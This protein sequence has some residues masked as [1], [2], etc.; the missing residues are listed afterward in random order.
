MVSTR[1]ECAGQFDSSTIFI[2]THWDSWDRSFYWQSRLYN[3]N[4]QPPP[5]HWLAIHH[6][7]HV[8]LHLIVSIFFCKFTVIWSFLLKHHWLNCP[9]EKLGNTSKS[10]INCWSS[11]NH[12]NVQYQ[13]NTA[14]C[15]KAFN[16]LVGRLRTGKLH[17]HDFSV[18]VPTVWEPNRF[19][20]P[21]GIGSRRVL[22]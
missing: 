14:Q 4:L 22:C 5:G 9:F 3:S 21:D 20:H 10:D 2:L 18:V 19:R 1:Q 13:C 11:I 6:R 17:R 8:R 12:I 15:C 7:T 16:S